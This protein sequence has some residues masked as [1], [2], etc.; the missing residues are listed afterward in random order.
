M[1]LLKLNNPFAAPIYHEETV[2]STFD[3]ARI[4]AGQNEPHG[5]VLTADFQ[6]AGRGRLNRRWVTERGKSLMFTIILRYADVLSMPVALTLRT[7]LAVSL[8]IEDLTGLSEKNIL[9]RRARS[10]T[11]KNTKIL[12]KTPCNSAYSVVNSYLLD[13]PG[14]VRI[15]WPNDVMINGRKAAGILTE[16]D[17]KT[18]YIGVG[19]NVAQEEFPEQYRSRAGSIIHS[20]PA[21]GENA[22]FDLLEKILSR[23]YAEIEKQTADSEA[24]RERLLLRLYKKGETVTFAEGAADSEDL[25]EGILSGLGPD[26]ELLIIPG[27]KE[28][29]R[30]FITGELRVY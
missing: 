6:E 11:E 7:G 21:L 3:L 16:A 5:T 12:M 29:E 26:G 14:S 15:K 27:G 19:V 8:A 2:S 17:G 23:L 20:F 13:T 18:V 28:K 22:R 25:V 4:L 9:P 1:K 30:S 10:I 24:W